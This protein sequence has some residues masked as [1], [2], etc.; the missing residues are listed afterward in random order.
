MNHTTW[1]VLE[2]AFGRKFCGNTRRNYCTIAIILKDDTGERHFKLIFSDSSSNKI[3]QDKKRYPEKTE[4][5]PIE[6]SIQISV[7]NSVVS[8]TRESR[9]ESRFDSRGNRG[10]IISRKSNEEIEQAHKQIFYNLQYVI[11]SS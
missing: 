9:G 5:N 11:W 4:K 2:I 1:N 6:R 10:W 8:K 7:E 3:K